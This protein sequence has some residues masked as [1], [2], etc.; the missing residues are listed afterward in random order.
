MKKFEK[1]LLIS[2]ILFNRAYLMEY[3][4]EVLG[5]MTDLDST[6]KNKVKW[7]RITVRKEH[8][9]IIKEF[10]C[11]K[12][13]G[14]YIIK[15]SKK[16]CGRTDLKVECAYKRTND[17][18]YEIT[19]FIGIESY[20]LMYEY[21]EDT[22]DSNYKNLKDKV[23]IYLLDKINSDTLDNLNEFIN[24]RVIPEPDY[25]YE[26]V[27]KVYEINSPSGKKYWTSMYDNKVEIKE[28]GNTNIIMIDGK[29]IVDDVVDII[30]K[31][32]NIA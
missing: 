1:Q 23:K 13:I 22:I 15:L 3:P 28:Y 26:C 31:R 16:E 8:Y 25:S 18:K 14:T 9:M 11:D 7:K 5:E 24:T 20:D 19:I 6:E 10:Y 4:V 30:K 17:N 27:G 29:Y 2:I 21:L 12:L 32:E